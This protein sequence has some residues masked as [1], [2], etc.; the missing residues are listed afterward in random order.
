MRTRK[1]KFGIV[2]TKQE[3]I[4]PIHHHVIEQP[5]PAELDQEPPNADSYAYAWWCMEHAQ[6]RM[7]EVLDAIN[8]AQRAMTPSTLIFNLETS[9]QQEA[10]AYAA[11]LERLGQS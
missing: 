10:D 6:R 7:V 9:Y 11:A 5:D 4:L 1:Q 8:Q 3:K 2:V